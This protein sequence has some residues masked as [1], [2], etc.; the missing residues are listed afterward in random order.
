MSWG[1]LSSSAERGDPDD[2]PDRERC[3]LSG[4][5]AEPEREERPDGG[6]GEPREIRR[7]CRSHRQDGEQHDGDGD[8]LEPVH[9]TGA[10]DVGRS[11]P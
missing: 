8:Q 3:R 2:G 5:P 10:R 6:D 7:K 4:K 1:T 11:P 9:P